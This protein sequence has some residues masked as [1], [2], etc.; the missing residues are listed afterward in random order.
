MTDHF[1]VTVYHA[2]NGLASNPHLHWLN[3]IMLFFAQ[4]ALEMYAVMFIVGWFILPKSDI[5][6]R[7]ALVMSGLAGILALIINVIIANAWFRPR[8]FTVL[9]QGS[10]TQLLP[11]APDASFPSDHASGSW[12]FAAGSWGRAHK[13]FQILFT[14]VAIIVMFARV[15]VG[16]HW[17]T[18]VIA[19]FFVGLFSGQII[20]LLSRFVYPITSTVARWFRFGEPKGGNQTS[21][22]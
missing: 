18:D 20:W 12:A 5:R 19:S 3:D 2:I 14:A 22:F 4:Y 10:F 17:P 15:Y 1:D 8:P 9:P 6:G 21:S 7:H 16:V 13:W 11:H